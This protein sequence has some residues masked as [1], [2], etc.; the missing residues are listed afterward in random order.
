[1]LGGSSS[2][3]QFLLGFIRI[4]RIIQVTRASKQVDRILLL[5]TVRIYEISSTRI[6]REKYFLLYFIILLFLNIEGVRYIYLCLAAKRRSLSGVKSE[7]KGL[8]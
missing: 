5:S 4:C 1:M 6:V 7:G 3:V 2:C 8:T